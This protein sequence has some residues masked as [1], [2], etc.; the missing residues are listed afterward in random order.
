MILQFNFAVRVQPS[1]WAICTSTNSSSHVGLLMRVSNL[2][3]DEDL[4]WGPEVHFSPYVSWKREHP[5]RCV[6]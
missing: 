4:A 1:Q 2:E 5:C 6:K 3:E